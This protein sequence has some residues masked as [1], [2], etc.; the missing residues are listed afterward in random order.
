N[1]ISATVHWTPLEDPVLLPQGSHAS[2]IRDRERHPE[3]ILI[4]LAEREAPVLHAEA[5]TVRVVGD[6]ALRELQN[7]LAI[8]VERAEPVIPSA[9]VIAAV[10]NLPAQLV[11]ARKRQ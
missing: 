9:P 5:A 2:D 8:V 7:A 6:L 3:L 1:D 10:S 11:G 4:A